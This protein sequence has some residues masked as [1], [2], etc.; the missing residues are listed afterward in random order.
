MDRAVWSMIASMIIPTIGG[1]IEKAKSPQ[2]AQHIA[3]V[4]P[5]EALH[6]DGGAVPVLDRQRRRAIGMYRAS[7]QPTGAI[8]Y[9]TAQSC[10][11]LCGSH[12][13]FPCVVPRRGSK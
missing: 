1:I 7:A 10:R 3:A 4:T 6:Q 2:L 11:D 5:G 8:A 13:R 12:A 9:G